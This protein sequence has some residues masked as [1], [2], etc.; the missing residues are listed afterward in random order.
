MLAMAIGSVLCLNSAHGSWVLI[1]DFQSYDTGNVDDGVTGGNWI[2]HG[3]TGAAEIE[4]DS[5]GKYIQTGIDGSRRTVSSTLNS[6]FQ[7]GADDGVATYFMRVRTLE[8][9]DDMFFG[10]AIENRNTS[11]TQ[12][13]FSDYVARAGI[14]GKDV[15]FRDGGTT[16][17]SSATV[18]ADEW[19]NFWFVLDRSTGVESWDLYMTTGNISATELNKVNTDTI[20][21]HNS[22]TVGSVMLVGSGSAE[23][24]RSGQMLDIYYS[25]GENLSMIPEPGTYAALVALAALGFTFYRRRKVRQKA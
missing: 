10:L 19:I 2:A 6:D 24:P 12:L 21:F 9:N 16:T 20:S 11:N 4:Q 23:N 25:D 17:T 7:L 8:G 22:G 3:G 5:T 15:V 18:D 14:V 1:D 13:T